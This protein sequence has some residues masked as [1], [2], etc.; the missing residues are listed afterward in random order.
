MS[1][2]RTAPRRRAGA[3]SDGTRAA[4]SKRVTATGRGASPPTSVTVLAHAKLNLGLAVG[5]RRD[6][7]FHDLVT[8]FQSVSLADTLI[9]ERRVRGF[10]LRVRHE[11]AAVH[12]RHDVQAQRIVRA[13]ASNLV[14]R[15][16][17]LV[18]SGLGLPGGAR[19]TL[20]KRIPAQA[21]MGGGSADAAAAIVALCALHGHRLTR[22]ER[23]RYGLQLGSDVPFALSGGTMLGMGRGEVLSRLRLEAPFRAIIAMPKWRISTAEAF[24]R[25]DADRKNLTPW[26]HHLR[27]AMSVGRQRVEALSLMRQGNRFEQLLGRRRYEFASLCDR[28]RAA[29]LLQPR[30]TGSGSAVFA[31][32]PRGGSIREIAGRFSGD[33]PLYEVRS[34]G[35][36][37]RLQ[38]HASSTRPGTG[39]RGGA[40]RPRDGQRWRRTRAS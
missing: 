4:R 7:G 6:D 35:K 39:A 38:L 27:F 29:G 20:V 31:I 8:V 2:P 37:L 21:G 1:L 30:L 12:G 34:V 13:D 32:M 25:H 9:A 18:A 14:L 19:F 15:A 17:R 24:H 11:S 10:S 16:A 40:P 28:L 36:G 23:V 5:P 33:E 26:K 22:T 3:S